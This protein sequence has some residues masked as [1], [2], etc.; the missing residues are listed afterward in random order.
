MRKNRFKFTTALETVNFNSYIFK[1]AQKTHVTLTSTRATATMII[2][3][4]IITKTEN[5]LYSAIKCNYVTSISEK[6]HQ[7]NQLKLKSLYV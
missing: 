7:Q 1:H 4:Q 5:N 3:M 2:Q 6:L